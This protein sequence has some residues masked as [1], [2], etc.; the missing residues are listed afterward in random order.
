[1][2]D[3]YVE[4]G[5]FVRLKNLSIRYHLPK[6]LTNKIGINKL[7][8][9]LTGTVLLTITKYSGFNP[10]ANQSGGSNTILG[11]DYNTYPTRASISGG[12]TLNF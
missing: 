4:D 1:M 5:S 11:I 6:S 10:E 7:S 2:I 8:V 12:V 3:K 9:F